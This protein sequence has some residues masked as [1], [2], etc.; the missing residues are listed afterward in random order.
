MPRMVCTYQ[1]DAL[2]PEQVR[3]LE[4]ALRKTYAERFSGAATP[5]VL[6]CE[7]PAGQAFTEARPSDISYVMVE[8]E[9][10]LDAPRREAAMMAL[11]ETW[12]RVAGVPIE[13]LMITLADSSLFNAYLKSNQARV[14]P[15]SRP[16]FLLSTLAHLW[17][18]RRRHGFLALRANL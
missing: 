5:T 15:L 12:A 8:V 13:M 6:W 10:G 16:W 18:S 4:A 7:L 14:R 1:Q 9:D 17:H 11:A 2:A 3:H